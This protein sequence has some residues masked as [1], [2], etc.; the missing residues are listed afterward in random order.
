ML[1]FPWGISQPRLSLVTTAWRHENMTVR[2]GHTTYEASGMG[3]ASTETRS[4]APPAAQ[5]T[6]N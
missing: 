4:T 2:E 1:E 3:M 6:S 5:M